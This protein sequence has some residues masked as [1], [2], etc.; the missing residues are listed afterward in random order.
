MVDY[1]AKSLAA[2]RTTQDAKTA[3]SVDP[4]LAQYL[5]TNASASIVDGV[6][7][8]ALYLLQSFDWSVLA[9]LRKLQ[10]ETKHPGIYII[11]YLVQTHGHLPPRFF[12]TLSRI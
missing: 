10:L 4:T 12:R 5:E 1:I 8:L 2:V 9:S 6:L 7:A 3:P 11:S